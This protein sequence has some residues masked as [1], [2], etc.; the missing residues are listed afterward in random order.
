MAKAGT[1]DARIL[2]P[3]SLELQPDAL[4]IFVLNVGDGDSVVIR[5][6]AVDRPTY[7][8]VDCNH[9]AKTDHL[10]RSLGRGPVVFMCATHPHLDHI[11]GLRH[12]LRTHGADEFW[13]SGFRYASTTYQALIEEVIDSG[14]RFVRPTAGFE[15]RH[16]ACRITVLSPSVQLKNRYDTYG[17]AINN[18]SVVLRLQYPVPPVNLDY[19]KTAN[20][21]ALPATPTRTMILG[22]DAQTDAWGAV[23][24]DF[25]HF[26]RDRRNWLRLM[27]AGQG[28]YPLATDFFKVPHH[29]SKRGINLELLERLGDRGRFDDTAPAY[30]A[31]SCAGGDSSSHGFPHRVSHELLRE[32]R[33]PIAA[34]EGGVHATDGE[35]GIHITGQELGGNAAYKHAG[36]IA[37]VVGADGGMTLYRFL[38]ATDEFVQLER[39]HRVLPSDRASWRRVAETDR[40]EVGGR[41][42]VVSW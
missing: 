32:A 27:R 13:D 6:P 1:L 3:Q 35:L 33:D 9:G 28:A 25:P 38:D 7:A 26:V 21:P 34:T 16:A 22:G 42:E 36:S 4:A 18:A 41:G 19:P 29:L 37:F 8:V 12:V 24:S 15:Y 10:L 17:I 23:M 5:F 40:N 31:V 30:M 14:L 2:E 20:F 39:A 11:R